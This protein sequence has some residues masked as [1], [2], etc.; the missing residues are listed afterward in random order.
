LEWL[1]TQNKTPKAK[2]TKKKKK[3]TMFWGLL[4]SRHVQTSLDNMFFFWFLFLFVSLF[5]WFLWFF[6]SLGLNQINRD[7]SK[8][9]LIHLAS[10]AF[11]SNHYSQ[12]LVCETCTVC[13]GDVQ[14]SF[15]GVK[16]LGM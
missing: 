5:F 13:L 3:Q 12:N 7:E 15:S 16:P 11:L 9:N 1:T 8:P 2:K 4:G 14:F 6:D 10:K